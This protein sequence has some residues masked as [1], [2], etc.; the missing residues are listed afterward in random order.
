V[1]VQYSSKKYPC[2]R[3]FT[4]AVILSAFV[5]M[6]TVTHIQSFV[7]MTSS[8]RRTSANHISSP[9]HIIPLPGF[10]ATS[11]FHTKSSLKCSQ[12]YFGMWYRKPYIFQRERV[13]E[14]LGIQRE[15]IFLFRQKEKENELFTVFFLSPLSYKHS[16]IGICNT[17]LPP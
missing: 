1:K 14:S 11:E 6:E 10:S 4:H 9:F 17:V 8:R 13:N 16:T 5:S 15:A 12:V 2:L 3:R 7:E